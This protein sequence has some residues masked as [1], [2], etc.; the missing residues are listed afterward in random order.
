MVK[1]FCKLQKLLSVLDAFKM[2]LSGIL[3]GCLIVLPTEAFSQTKT[4][5]VKAPEY[6]GSA[7]CA[8][9]HEQQFSAWSK[10]HHNAALTPPNS[11][12]VL[13]NFENAEFIH[14]GVTSKFFTKNGS[15]FVN[16]LG[17]DGKP[18]DFKI[19]YVVGIEPLQQYLIKLDK[20]RLQ[21]FDV[22]WDAI[23]KRWFHI[24]PDQPNK[25]GDGLHWTGPY[26]NWQAQCAECHQTQFIKGYDPSKKTYD[27]S[28]KE[29]NVACGACHGPGEAHVAWARKPGEF[30]ARAFSG[31]N[32]LGLTV[33]FPAENPNLELKV[34]ARCHSRR[35][36]FGADSPSPHS[37]FADNYNL[38]LLRR[39][40][41][42]ADGQIEDEVY[43]YGSFL[44]SKMHERGVRCSNCHEPHSVELKAEG[45]AVCTQCHS[46]AGNPKFPTLK[47]KAYDSASHH[48]HELENDGAKCVSCHMPQKTYMMVD[49]RR[50]HS[51]RVP[52]PDLSEKL[53][54][55]NACTACHTD[56]SP[57]WATEHVQNWYPNGRTGNPHFSELFSQAR[58]QVIGNK[59]RRSLIYLAL[60]TKSP[61]II[62]ATSL[63]ELSGQMSADDLEKITELLE[64][65]DTIVRAA[66]PQLFRGASA[67]LRFQRLIPMLKDPAKSVRVAAVREL[68]NVPPGEF[69]QTDRKLVQSAMREYQLSLLAKAD[70]PQIQMVFGGLAMATRNFKAAEAAFRES[71]SMDPQLEQAWLI[72]ARIQMAQSRLPAARKTLLAAQEKIPSSPQIHRM[73][74]TVSL[75]LKQPTIAVESL[76]KAENLLPDDITVKL[77]LGNAQMQAKNYLEAIGSLAEVLRR[78]PNNADALYL[79]A[80]ANLSLGKVTKAKELTQS[81]MKKHPSFR[82]DQRLTPLLQLP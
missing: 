4:S 21:A 55:P 27:S 15:Y 38:A 63:G 3:F 45:N 54:T 28:W 32:A 59:L 65:D 60:D 1:Y 16:T 31:V 71:V 76:K 62:R 20:G 57:N 39:G 36:A 13:G 82:L 17:A 52:R 30:S 14:K 19:E 79:S 75:Q 10:S 64:D 56:K 66:A 8:G 74:A 24:F 29:L 34:C 42:H 33:D 80:H 7:T 49:P 50:D 11:T 72:I 25:P 40:L 9:C 6:V 61:A 53:G 47:M 67:G 81:L 41:Y 35:E 68:L 22:A 18:D 2:S 37:D 51:F 23:K 46:P 5:P 58:G 69:S 12:T 44:Q 77:E 78:D 26:K 48:H 70:F 43:V 73:F